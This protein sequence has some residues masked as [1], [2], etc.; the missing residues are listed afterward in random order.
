MYRAVNQVEPGL[1]R[2]RAD[3]VTY[4]LHIVLRFELE[5]ALLTNDL[6]VGDLPGAWNDKMR[7]YLGLTPPGDTDGVLQDIHWSSGLVGSFPSY[8]LGNVAS[9]QLFEAARRAYPSIPDD[10]RGGRF[11]TLYGWM[12]EHVYVHGRKFL[13]SEVLQRATGTP[14]TAEPY[15]KYLQDKFGELYGVTSEH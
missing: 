10:L 9:V 13:P 4:N 2:V 14:L 12:R 7:A 5:K 11:G 1:I 3:E 15:L 8:T 6:A